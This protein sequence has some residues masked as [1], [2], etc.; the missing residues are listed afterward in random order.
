MTFNDDKMARRLAALASARRLAVPTPAPKKK[1][2]EERAETRRGVYRPGRL[3]VTGGLELDC[4]IVDL[5]ANGARLHLDG[6]DAL[7]EFLTLRVVSTGALKR[8]RVVW[9]REHSAGLSFLMERSVG[10]ATM[11][12]T[13]EGR[14]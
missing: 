3:I 9:R 11:R 7:P 4:M 8:A 14:S 13:D 6:A 1:V 2:E 5:S 12:P 10:F